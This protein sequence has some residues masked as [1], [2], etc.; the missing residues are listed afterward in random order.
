MQALKVVGLV[1][2]G[3]GALSLAKPDLLAR[4]LKLTDAPG[5]PNSGAVVASYAVGVR[6]VASGLSLVLLPAGRARTLAVA[7]RVLLDV[8]DGL[9]WPRAV[10]DP[11]VQKKIQAGALGWGGVCALAGVASGVAS[12]RRS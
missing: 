7:A 6:D 9:L 5:G 12:H 3:Y 11:K 8:T 2:A 10:T 4:Q 1:T